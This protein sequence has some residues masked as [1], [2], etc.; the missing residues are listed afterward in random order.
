MKV[1]IILND[2]GVKPDNPITMPSIPVA[3]NIIVKN[4]TRVGSMYLISAIKIRHYYKLTVNLIV[5]E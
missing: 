3:K 1:I 5:L 2:A 4:L